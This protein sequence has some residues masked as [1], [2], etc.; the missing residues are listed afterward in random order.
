M[1]VT[2]PLVIASAAALAV[3]GAEIKAEIE[4]PIKPSTE[5]AVVVGDG[6]QSFS[7]YV[8]ALQKCEGSSTW[9]IHGLWP[10][11]GSGD[12]PEWCSN[13]F[14]INQLSSIRSNL[15]NAWPNCDGSDVTPFWSHEWER[16][17]SC[18]GL[19][20]LGFFSYALKL[21]NAGAWQSQC[22]NSDSSECKVSYNAVSNEFK[23]V[24]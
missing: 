24:Q 9:T 6:R 18:S 17:G 14:D 8:F 10:S 7:Y 21:Y 15:D 12:G 13:S 20:E 4:M 2:L 22:D 16:H 3:S 19:G 5:K 23:K 1:R 11:S